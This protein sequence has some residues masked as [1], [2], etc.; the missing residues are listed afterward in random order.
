MR[1]LMRSGDSPLLGAVRRADDEAVAR[2]VGARADVGEASAS[3][4]TPLLVACQEG[5]TA[6]LRVLLDAGAIAAVEEA[7]QDGR[8]PLMVACHYGHA[9]TVKALLAAGASVGPA[10]RTTPLLVAVTPASSG[11]WAP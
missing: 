6:I 1:C 3:G 5:F 8:T 7:H 9:E 10:S 11:L 2:L 4:A